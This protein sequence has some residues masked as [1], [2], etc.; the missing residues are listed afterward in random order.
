MSEQPLEIQKKIRGIGNVFNYD[1]VKDIYDIYKPILRKINNNHID[2]KKNLSYGSNARNLLDIHW[3][4]NRNKKPLPAIVYL[5]GGGFVSGNKN[6][7]PDE[8]ELIHGNIL[9]YFVNNG[10]IGINA[11]YRL[12]PEHKYPAGA[13]DVSKII[14]YLIENSE[15]FGISTN[16]IYLF[17]Q[18]AG[19]SHVASYLFNNSLEIKKFSNVAGC[20]LFSGAY[21]LSI[22]NSDA[23]IQYYGNEKS[24]YEKMSS[25]NFVTNDCCPI[26][27]TISEFD[28]P[29]FKKQGELLYSKLLDKGHSPKFK[30][31]PNHNHISQVIHF[32]TNDESIGPDLVKFINNP[33]EN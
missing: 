8:P 13:E 5:H 32:N 4:K 11:T 17:G 25:I 33:K 22:L 3:L 14:Q 2:I 18:S 10:F 15:K 9:N 7:L 29:I 6:A 24:L 19:A 27:I 21:N 30:I 16:E 26:F 12:A 31:I 28:P 20:I 23:M 1:V